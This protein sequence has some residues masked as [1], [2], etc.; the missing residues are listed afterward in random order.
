MS[1]SAGSRPRA[2]QQERAMLPASRCWQQMYD[3]GEGTCS[4]PWGFV[5]TSSPTRGEEDAKA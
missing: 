2:Q 4:A 1:V 3:C 5:A